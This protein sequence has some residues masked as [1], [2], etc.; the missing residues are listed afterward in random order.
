MA[1]AQA[2]QFRLLCQPATKLLIYIIHTKLLKQLM[3]WQA[4]LLYSDAKKL[5]QEQRFVWM[6]SQF[7]QLQYLFSHSPRWVK[8]CCLSQVIQGLLIVLYNLGDGDYNITL[9]YYRIDDGEWHE[10][11]MNRF[12]REFTLRLDGG[13]GRR[14]ITAS[15]GRS[16]EIIIDPSV[17]MIGNSFPSG[18]NRSFVGEWQSYCL[19]LKVSLWL[20]S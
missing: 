11:E 13:G 10:V 7:K 20:I 9:P 15:P 12:G 4:S 16:Q 17:V 8:H 3:A 19:L 5:Q 6:W 2:C 1:A 14:E 18:H